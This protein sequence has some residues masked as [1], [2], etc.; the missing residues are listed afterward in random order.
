MSQRAARYQPTPKGAQRCDNCSQFDA[1]T[2]CKIVD[3]EVSPAGWCL[4][5]VAKR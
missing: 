5:Y 2:G 4:L 1:P 3:G